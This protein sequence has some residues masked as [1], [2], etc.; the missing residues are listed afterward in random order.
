MHKIFFF[1]DIHGM[2]DLYHAIIDYCRE[3]DPEALVIFGGDA[4]DRGPDGYKIMKDLLNRPRIKYLK[5]N[6]EDMFVK[7]AQEINN[8][9]VFAKTDTR[10]NIKTILHRA[11]F[12]D[13]EFPGIALAVYNGGLNT[14]VD[15]IIDGADMT[16]VK[17]IDNLPLTFCIG[18]HDFC[19]S[20]SKHEIFD[21][22]SEA[23]DDWDL[24]DTTVEN[25]E[26]MSLMWARSDFNL[27]WAPGRIVYF[28]HTPIPYLGDYIKD[29]DEN[30]EPQPYKW[31]GTSNSKLTG[32][33]VLMDTGACFTGIA[34][35]LDV[36]P[37]QAQGFVD[38]D[39]A[40]KEIHKHEIK[41]FYNIQ[42]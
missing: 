12:N 30:A 4:C 38:T 2:Y 39:I 19:H 18:R 34:Y 28:G 22:V 24:T 35:V 13:D 6:H 16:F 9:F 36:L 37:M 5:G 17:R 15:W 1:T 27:G 42:L 40:N 7:A 14:L 31:V 32:E 20:A 25:A 23:E 21:H 41:K 26:A 10:E 29:W 33:K 3:Q 11:L 8:N